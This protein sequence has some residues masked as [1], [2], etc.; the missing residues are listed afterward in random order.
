MNSSL[1]L[2]VTQYLRVVLATLA[3]VVLIAFLSIPVALGG[4][5]D[6]TLSTR[7]ALTQHMT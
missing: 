1:R 5:A 7:A 3:P 6:E 2:F 4:H